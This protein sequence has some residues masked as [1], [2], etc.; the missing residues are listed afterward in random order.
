[1]GGFAI[2][3]LVADGAHDCRVADRSVVERN[4]I[5]NRHWVEQAAL[6][7]LLDQGSVCGLGLGLLDVAVLDDDLIVEAALD[8]V[9]DYRGDLLRRPGRAS[10]T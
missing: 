5:D 8:L 3:D 4:A 10:T 7:D 9:A 6:V 2:R 1:L